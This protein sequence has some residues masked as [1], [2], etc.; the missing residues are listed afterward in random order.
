MIEIYDITDWVNSLYLISSVFEQELFLNILES[1]DL[2]HGTILI[3]FAR[4]QYSKTEW[5][6]GEFQYLWLVH[7]VQWISHQRSGFDPFRPEETS[8]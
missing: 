1:I 5:S 4:A 8:S 3:C 2:Y 6:A 7:M